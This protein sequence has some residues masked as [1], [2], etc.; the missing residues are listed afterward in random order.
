[1][2]CSRKELILSALL[3]N[4]TVR[5]ASKVCGVAERTIYQWL[6][7]PDF[8]KKY[9]E[10]KARIV[11]DSANYLQ[12]KL[13]EAT[14]TIMD[15][16]IDE[17]VATQTRLNAARTVFE[18]CYKLREQKEVIARLTAIEDAILEVDNG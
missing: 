8:K 6:E 11:E 9:E 17:K 13:N 2:K 7:K 10:M 3:T 18:Y 4:P 12:V 16:M 5:E 15:I 14:K 1:M